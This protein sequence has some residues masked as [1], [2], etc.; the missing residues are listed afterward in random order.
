MAKHL[1][2]KITDE[3]W[4]GRFGY[5]DSLGSFGV[6]YKLENNT[7][8]ILPSKL[9]PAKVVAPDLR[10]GFAALMCALCADGESLIYSAEL[11]LRGYEKICEKLRALGAEI[12]IN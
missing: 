9:T 3:V 10:G 2:G 7:A 11:I 6:K 4:Q 5:L 12:I 1:G 8:E